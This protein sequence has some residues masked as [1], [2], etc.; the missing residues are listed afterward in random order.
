M[1]T[2]NHFL[3]AAYMLSIRA[4]SHA[5]RYDAVGEMI[6]SQKGEAIWS[7]AVRKVECRT[8]ETYSYVCVSVNNAARYTLH[9]RIAI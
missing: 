8:F 5:C 4:L 6:A 9:V 7:E 2:F 3:T 1:D